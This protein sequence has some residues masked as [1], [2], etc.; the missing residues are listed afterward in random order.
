MWL[1][2]LNFAISH[3]WRSGMV[4]PSIKSELLTLDG[5]VCYLKAGK[6]P[7]YRLAS[8]GQ[9]PAPKLRCTCRFQR[10][11]LD[12]WTDSLIVMCDE[13]KSGERWP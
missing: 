12:R 6:R 9:I 5:V 7:V 1:T 10:A 2:W 13:A 4:L 8:N 3:S 11:E